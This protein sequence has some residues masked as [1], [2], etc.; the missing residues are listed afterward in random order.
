[1]SSNNN[2][3]VAEKVAAWNGFKDNEARQTRQ[4][5]RA[6]RLE[7]MRENEQRASQPGQA[8]TPDWKAEFNR[9]A[10]R[11]RQ[12]EKELRD[13]KD[14]SKD[15]RAQLEAADEEGADLYMQLVAAYQE[16]NALKSRVAF[17]EKKALKEGTAVPEGQVSGSKIEPPETEQDAI[18]PAAIKTPSTEPAAIQQLDENMGIDSDEEVEDFAADDESGE[19]ADD[20]S[21]KGSIDQEDKSAEAEK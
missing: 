16:V 19:K 12:L 9:S 8:R 2:Q 20:K 3:T 7:Q 13:E 17:L 14:V 6:A 11:E 4:A 1:M 5:V 10:K 21:D 15:L 18:Q